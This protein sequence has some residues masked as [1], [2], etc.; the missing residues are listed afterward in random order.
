[1]TEATHLTRLDRTQQFVTHIGRR[2]VEEAVDLLSA[3]VVYHVPGS[4][5]LSGTFAGPDAVRAHLLK[6]DDRAR[7]TFEATK[8]EDWL[9]GEH[10]VAALADFT[11]SADGRLAASRVLYLFKFDIADLI[12]GISVFFDEESFALRFFGPAATGDPNT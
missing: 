12:V 3:K 6:L 9:V 4:H 1:M 7:G 8:W 11:M 10:H 2:D 5:A